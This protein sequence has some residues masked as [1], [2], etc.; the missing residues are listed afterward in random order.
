MLLFLIAYVF[1][2]LGATT[3]Y[4]SVIHYIESTVKSDKTTRALCVIFAG[5][6]WLVIFA[7]LSVMFKM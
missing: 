5:I 7:A 3:F 4:F 1:V 6:G 2:V